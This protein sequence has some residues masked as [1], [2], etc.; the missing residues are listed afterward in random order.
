ML[1]TGEQTGTLEDALRRAAQRRRDTA[2]RAAAK[3]GK[4]LAVGIYAVGLGV[5]ALTVVSFYAGYGSLLRGLRS[6]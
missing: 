6:H 4:G 2:Q 5:A 3:I 1:A